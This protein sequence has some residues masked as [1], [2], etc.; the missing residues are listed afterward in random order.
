MQKTIPINDF[1]MLSGKF[2]VVDV[3]SPGEFA[4]GHF[5]G[6]V[7]I[8]LFSNEERAR[9]GIVYTQENP[10]KALEEGLRIV[11]PKMV[12]FVR[13]AKKLSGGNTLLLYC[14]RGGQRS[15]SMSWL[16]DTA[17]ISNFVLKGGYQAFR[18]HIKSS[19]QKLMPLIILGGMTGTGKTEILHVL[20]KKGEQIIDLEHLAHHKGS[21]FGAMGQGKQPTTEQFENCLF[22]EWN[23]LDPR[24]TVWIEDESK[25]IGRVFIPDELFNQ[26]KTAP[27]FNL[28]LDR[29]YR[30]SRLV[31]DYALFDPDDLILSVHKIERRLGGVNTNLC[32]EAIRQKDFQ[33]AAD[34]LLNY[35]DKTY[36]HAMT[37]YSRKLHTL[38]LPGNDPETNAQII[39]SVKANN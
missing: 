4:H 18:R 16:F 6:A 2:P 13:Q 14:W 32:I 29:K 10:N 39:L 26:M 25:T 9:V 3:R 24:K 37:A 5:P 35:Y 22:I 36:T 33:R 38:S 8:P 30:I 21:V 34:I 20:R 27:L 17:G 28:N 31:R 1:L 11:G 19:L 7:N 15:H 23:R 12:F